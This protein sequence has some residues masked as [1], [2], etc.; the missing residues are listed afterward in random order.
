MYQKIYFIIALLFSLNLLSQNKANDFHKLKLTEL[1]KTRVVLIDT[2]SI[3]TIKLFGG[4]ENQLKNHNF[5]NY[6]M[7]LDIAKFNQFINKIRKLAYNK[8]A[9]I[10]IG[11][12]SNHA[13][14]KSDIVSNYSHCDSMDIE[15]YDKNG[16]SYFK[17]K[18]ICDSSCFLQIIAIDFYETWDFISDNGMIEKKVLAYTPIYYD[19]SKQFYRSLFTVYLDKKTLELIA[20][21]QQY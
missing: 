21:K 19:Y 10:S 18:L 8:N 6:M 15:E 14:E 2:T 20:E 4:E 16:Y 17:K 9:V 1:I 3:E 5:E 11:G 7:Y 12:L 13:S